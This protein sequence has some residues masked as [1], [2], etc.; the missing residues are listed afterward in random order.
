MKNVMTP[1]KP[2]LGLSDETVNGVVGILQTLLA[3]E[4]TLY[5]RLRNYR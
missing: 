1:I 2:N 4:M 3:D 5:T